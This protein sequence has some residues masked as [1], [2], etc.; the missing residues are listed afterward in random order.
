VALEAATFTRYTDIVILAC[1]VLAVT[2]ALIWWRTALPAGAWRWW[3]GSV[4]VFGAGVAV[5][6]A[7]IYGGPLRSGYRPGEIQFSLNAVGPNLRYMPARLVEAMP[8]LVLG[9]LALAAIA[10]GWVRRR[11]DPGLPGGR[12]RRDLAVGLGL[13][14]S[15]AG[16]WGLYAAY[17][18]TAQAGAAGP[19]LPNIRFYLPAVGAIALLAAWPVV[20]GGHWL[21]ARVRWT[22]L[23]VPALALAALFGLGIWSFTSLTGWAGSSGRGLIP[24]TRVAPAQPGQGP[25]TPN[26]GPVPFNQPG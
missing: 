5:F 17:T 13:G 3:L 15:W 16:M 12:A 8:M 19:S 26:Q 9:L 24:V 1:A 2:A 6:D 25:A 23:A 21:A 7:L 10:T 22:G 11:H 20:Y 4:A 14:T 18:W